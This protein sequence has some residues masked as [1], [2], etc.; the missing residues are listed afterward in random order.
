MENVSENGT[1]KNLKN[2]VGCCSNANYRDMIQLA[3]EQVERYRVTLRSLSEADMES[4]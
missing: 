4:R 2:F 1:K 3:A